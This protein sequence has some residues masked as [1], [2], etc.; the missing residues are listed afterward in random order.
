MLLTL[1]NTLLECYWPGQM[2]EGTTSTSISVLASALIPNPSPSSG[3]SPSWGVL[4]PLRVNL[5]FGPP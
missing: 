2:L 3:P 1:V 5:G 4:H